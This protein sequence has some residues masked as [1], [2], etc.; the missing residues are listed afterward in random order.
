VKLLLA[1][2]HFAVAI[3]A[4]ACDNVEV[5]ELNLYALAALFTFCTGDCD[6]PENGR[7]DDTVD[8]GSGD[9]V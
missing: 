4:S 5:A 2:L 7:R 3:I 1:I 6:G 8:N 9:G